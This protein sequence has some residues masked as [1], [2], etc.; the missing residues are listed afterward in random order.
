MRREVNI[1][2]TEDS[3]QMTQ[4]YNF[5]AAL[6]SLFSQKG[7]KMNTIIRASLAVAAGFI[8]CTG[9]QAATH[10]VWSE[11]PL[12]LTDP[13]L[14]SFSPIRGNMATTWNSKTRYGHMHITAQANPNL[15][16]DFNLVSISS[17][18][19][20]YISGVW[21]IFRNGVLVCNGCI[22]KAYILSAPVG[23]YFKVYIGD[24][25]CAAERWHY[26]GYITNRFDF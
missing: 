19:A 10:S 20:D 2:Q 14:G 17:S 12:A 6:T 13:T 3:L 11:K 22:G 23:N 9:A 24:E 26:S 15:T 18:H 5:F 7:S 25:N 21:D 8:L 4:L 1:L 16:Y